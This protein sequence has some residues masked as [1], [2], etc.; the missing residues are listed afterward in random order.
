[1]K[2][3]PQAH[4]IIA[5]KGSIENELLDIIDKSG[6]GKRI[7]KVGFLQQPF[8]ASA[9]KAM[10]VFVFSS[11]SETQGMVLSES[12]AAG[13]PVIALDAPGVREVV[14]D[15]QNGKLL[16]AHASYQNFARALHWFIKL[17]ELEKVDL[18]QGALANAELYSLDKC[19]QK[20]LQK[21]DQLLGA[22]YDHRY[23]EHQ[24]WTDT[25]NMIKAEYD[26][27]KGYAKAAARA[28]KHDNQQL[29]LSP[30]IISLK[31]HLLI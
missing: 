5:G 16:T 31:M 14:A 6:L 15:E 4:F 25:I 21:Y 24:L 12:M 26:I 7:H 27:V 11:Q 13:V 18:S 22:E 8:L 3:E 29:L 23:H 1:M 20:A 2:K 19:A 28:V 10:D 17:S 30:E 9:Y